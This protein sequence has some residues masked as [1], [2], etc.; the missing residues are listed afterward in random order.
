MTVTVEAFDTSGPGD[1]E[2][3]I[4]L[5]KAHP[6]E[7]IRRLALLVKVE[8]SADRNDFSR[9]HATYRAREA[10]V[11]HGGEDLAE[12]TVFLHST[13][14]EGAITPFGYF[15]ADVGPR[16][17][18]SVGVARSGVVQAHDLG[19]LAHAA[20]VERTVAEAIADA[21]LTAGDVALVVVKTPLGGITSAY[22]KAVGALGSALALGDVERERVVPEAF[23]RDLGL[24]S[25]RTMVFSSSEATFVE[26]LVLGGS[27]EGLRVA[28]GPIADMLDA[29][30]VRRVLREAGATFT[31]DGVVADPSRVAALLVK[32][33]HRHDGTLRGNRITVLTSHLDPDKHVR[34][35]LSGTAG[36]VLGDGRMFVTAGSLHQA[37]DGGGLCVA[38]VR[39]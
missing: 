36:S 18:L 8:G 32:G 30:G 27:G 39:P 7:E 2:G 34:A 5:L 25:S 28:T 24:Y 38:I 9:E 23:G 26:V 15:I 12:R 11:A 6:P 29:P 3:L 17:G 35:V 14:S 31:D 13:G 19:T 10:V 33:G 37:A 22:A 16:E 20:T 1:T 21:G 4:A